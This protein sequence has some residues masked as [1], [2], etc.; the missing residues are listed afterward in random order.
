MSKSIIVATTFLVFSSSLAAADNLPL[1]DVTADGTWDC[2]D[3]KGAV[4]GAVAVAEK[5]YAFITPDGRRAGHGKLFQIV[6]GLDLPTFAILDG[7]LKD[8]RGSS[9]FAMRGPKSNP[10]DYSG[11]LYLNVILS[12][13]GGGKLDWDC[14][15]RKAPAT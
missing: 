12:P 3:D 10:H 8:E 2:K 5:T 9:G 15:R 6:E 4:M 13:G 14:V 1:R 7:Y 11:E